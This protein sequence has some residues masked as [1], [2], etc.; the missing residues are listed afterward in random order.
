MANFIYPTT[1]NITSGFRPPDRPNHNGVDF[2]R[3][4]NEPIYASAGGTVSRSYVSDSYGEVIF[5]KHV[6]NGQNYETVYAHM[7]TGS[8]LA[9]VGQTVTQ[10]QQIGIMGTTGDSTGIHLHFELHIPE[11][12]QGGANAVNPIPYLEGTAQPPT[13]EIHCKN[14]YLTLS[15]MTVNANYLMYKMTQMGWSKNAIAGFL[16]NAQTESTINPCLWQNLD[17][18]NMSLGFGLVQWTPATKL[19]AW[20]STEGLDPSNIDTQLGRLQYE[21]NNGLQ[22][23]ATSE[24]PMSFEDFITSEESPEYLA[25]AFLKNYERAGVEKESERREQAR[26]WFDNWNG[27]WNGGG[28]VTDKEK[29]LIMT[30]RQTNMRRMGI[31][32]RR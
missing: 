23:I 13:G 24:Y 11:W 1:Q 4:Q 32:G 22:W 16:G 14:Q 25:S 8:R 20:A 7:A 28:Q 29:W 21:L 9:G 26:Y 5:I 3:G 27:E 15:E 31:R 12:V 19:I 17:Q 6:I 2:S 18:G 30:A 10:G